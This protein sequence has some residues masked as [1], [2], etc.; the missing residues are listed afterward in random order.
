MKFENKFGASKERDTAGVSC[1][2]QVPIKSQSVAQY[3]NKS[4]TCT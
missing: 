4:D 3:A 1:L 2:K